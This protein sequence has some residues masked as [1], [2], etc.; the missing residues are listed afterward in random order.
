M[1]LRSSAAFLD[2]VALS[3]WW[4]SQAQHQPDAGPQG[5][6]VEGFLDPPGLARFQELAGV[7]PQRIAGDQEGTHLRIQ[8]AQFA[9]QFHPAD[10]G[11]DNGADPQDDPVARGREQ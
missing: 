11:H 7:P 9:E 5:A 1:A 3:Y 4:R 2:V 6:T 10:A 8:L